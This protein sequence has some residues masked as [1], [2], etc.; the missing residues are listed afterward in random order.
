MRNE[1]DRNRT[2]VLII[3]TDCLIDRAHTAAPDFP[4]D[5]VRPDSSSDLR[6]GEVALHLYGECSCGLTDR[7]TY[8]RSVGLLCTPVAFEEQVD[9]TPEFRVVGADCIEINARLGVRK[10]DRFRENGLDLSPA[11]LI[12]TRR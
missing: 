8:W 4:H 1:F 6:C 12:H 11:L 5:L 7:L 3:D 10:L 9:F 2:D